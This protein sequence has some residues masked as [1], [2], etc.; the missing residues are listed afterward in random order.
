VRLHIQY[1]RQEQPRRGSQRGT[2]DVIIRTMSPPIHTI[3]AESQYHDRS[4]CPT[5]LARTDQHLCWGLGVKR[6]CVKQLRA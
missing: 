1:P 3:N 5:I 4:V 2:E 6:H